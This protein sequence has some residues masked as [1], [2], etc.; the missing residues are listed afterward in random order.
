MN[1]DTGVE[2]KRYLL[3]EA[4]LQ[5][6]QNFIEKEFGVA[7]DV[8]DDRRNDRYLFIDRKGK[9]VVVAILNFDENLGKYV[10]LQINP[11]LKEMLEEADKV[12]TEHRVHF[13]LNKDTIGVG[14][15]SE[16]MENLS[17]AGAIHKTSKIEL[18][19][20][21]VSSAN[22]V[23]LMEWLDYAIN[24]IKSIC[25]T[26]VDAN[27]KSFY[28]FYYKTYYSQVLFAY[29]NYVDQVNSLVSYEL[30]KDLI[31]QYHEEFR[32]SCKSFDEVL[33]ANEYF[34]NVA[35]VRSAFAYGVMYA[36][37][38][39]LF[40]NDNVKLLG[41]VK[42]GNELIFYEDKEPKKYVIYVPIRFVDDKTSVKEVKNI[43][44]DMYVSS[45]Y[46]V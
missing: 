19:I 31:N 40:S 36:T 12:D 24:K 1:N 25:D 39:N 28:D 43:S 26:A 34:K 4:M 42:K 18:P 6:Y 35:F 41:E 20:W 14:V 45:S 33:R 10:P 3:S 30:N 27:I 17:K 7:V 8:M 11:K 2:K 13:E 23:L 38:G 22:D 37:D 5:T 9:S 16:G 46:L 21:N 29:Y 15:T 32:T 44:G